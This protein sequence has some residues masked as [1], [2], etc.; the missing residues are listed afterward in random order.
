MIYFDNAA[1]S[2]PKPP[3]V[4]RAIG[5]WLKNN[6]ANPGRSGHKP[7]LEAGSVVFDTRD[8]IC[9]MFGVG[10][11]ENI[12]FVPNATY[13]LNFIIQGLLKSG[14]HAVTTDLEHNS[15]VR[16][17]KLLEKR[18]VSFDVANVDLYDNSKTVD[19]ILKHIKKNTKL[20]ICTQCSNVCGKVMPVHEI[21][22]ALPDNVELLVDGAQGAGIIPTDI[23]KEG[24]DYY[25]APSHKGLMGPQGSGFI[26]VCGR[27]PRPLIV[28]GTGSESLDLNQPDYLPDLLESG[29]L[30]TPVIKGMYEGMKFIRG[31]GIDKIYQHKISLVRYAVNELN[32]LD[33]V[34]TY[35]NPDLSV[36]AGT[37]CFNVIGHDSDIVAAF[38]ADNDVCVRSGIHCAPLFHKKMGTE[39]TGMV[40]ISFSCFNTVSEID[41]FIKIMKKYLKK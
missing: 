29:T 25:C 13:G 33:G 24:I 22:A 9:Q 28:G 23:K 40:R 3:A 38:L 37:T 10:D 20:V 19:N 35:V 2:Y 21:S 4:S 1:S 16:P 14:D 27:P 18:G 6:G 41:V 11:P 8:L 30:P 32:A 7:A 36:F 26:A 5:T 17:L 15:V 31:V 12:V 39:K 34:V